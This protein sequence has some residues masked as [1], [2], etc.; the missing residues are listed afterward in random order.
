M[1]SEATPR[2]GKLGQFG[3]ALYQFASSPYFVIINIFV[4]NAYFQKNVVGDN[5]QGQ[6]IWGY[7][8]ATAGI[9]IPLMAPVLGALADAYGPRKPG[10]ILFSAIA[11]PAM[12]A[13]WFVTPGQVALGFTAIVLAAVA[14]ECAAIYHNAMLT[15]VAGARNVGFMSGLAYSLDYVGS[16]SMFVL[17]LTLPS[18]GILALFDGPFAHERL[19]GP[20][21]VAWLILFSL[22]LVLYTNDVPHAGLSL[23]A[24][25]GKGLRT[26]AATIARVGHYRNVATFLV[27]RAIYA[28]G[29]SAVFSFLA[30]YLSG[31]F[32]WPTAKIGIYALIVLTVPIFTSFVG[33]WVD[34]KIGSKRAVQISLLMFTLAVAGSVSTTPDS[35]LFFFPVTD[36]LREQ[37]LPIVGP[38]FNMFG[39]TQFPEQ[40][41]LA[42]SL[43][44]GAFVGPVLASSRTM[45][46]RI[47]P[48]SMISEVYGLYTLT[49]KATAFAAPF[50]VAVVTDAT[51]NQR[52]GFSVILVFLVVGFVGLWSVREE[53]AEMAP[54]RP[55]PPPPAGT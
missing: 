28:D 8:Q 32:G 40:I 34:D 23:A 33:G 37:Q 45:V 18:L 6:V 35:Y 36:S 19:A 12:L 1:M 55:A 26:L 46:A 17:W 21:S 51:Q 48:P 5:V 39:F 44:G 4:F 49:G 9:L 27:V 15:S 3:W 54:E 7:T 29:M 14:M 52:L 38:L 13:L 53:R 43:V 16:V 42:F 2:N 10:L 25:A 22:P 30:G 50:L 11:V 20:L 24:A 31:V 47:A 41:S